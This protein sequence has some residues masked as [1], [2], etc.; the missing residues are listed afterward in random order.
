[1]KP[2]LKATRVKKRR[3]F[4]MVLGITDQVKGPLFHEC[5]RTKTSEISKHIGN[6]NMMPSSAVHNRTCNS[7]RESG[8]TCFWPRRQ[9]SQ[10]PP[11]HQAAGRLSATGRQQSSNSIQHCNL[12][13]RWNRRTRHSGIGVS[14][15]ESLRLDKF[16]LRY[17]G[18]EKNKHVAFLR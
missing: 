14:R 13:Q 16:V 17:L 7:R 12:G 3:G 11:W 8:C 15:Q 9:P 2:G 6:L 1:M 10:P 4:L 18:L 5:L